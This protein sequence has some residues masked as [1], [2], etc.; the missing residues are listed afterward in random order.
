MSRKKR[1]AWLIELWDYHHG[2][3]KPERM[4]QIEALLQEDAKAKTDSDRVYQIINELRQAG[5]W[6]THPDFPGQMVE[7]ILASEGGGI[8]KKVLLAAVVLVV[9]W[10][11]W[12][13]FSGSGEKSLEP[14]RE[15]KEPLISPV[16]NDPEV[17]G[18]IGG[19]EVPANLGD[20]M[21][22]AEMGELIP[23]WRAVPEAGEKVPGMPS[24]SITA[25]TE[26]FQLR[27]PV[28]RIENDLD[29]WMEGP[30]V[31]SR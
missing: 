29:D 20:E 17:S 12:G 4:A 5:R 28:R 22:E 3:L 14:A 8:G 21:L 19:N 2:H 24:S 23:Q 7:R 18:E 27:D 9:L 13:F 25:G 30:L 11:V 10:L 26:T 15:M 1:K 6:E 31:P 16:P